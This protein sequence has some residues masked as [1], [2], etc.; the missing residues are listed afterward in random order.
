[1]TIKREGGEKEGTIEIDTSIVKV[2]ELDG[3]R[4]S[5]VK[6]E[7]LGIEGNGIGCEVGL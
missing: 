6:V 2:E 1:M 7:T 4:E 3:G 5:K